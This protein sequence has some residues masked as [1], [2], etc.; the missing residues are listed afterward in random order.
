MTAPTWRTAQV[1]VLTLALIVFWIASVGSFHTHELLLG[2]PAV[3]LSTAFSFYAIR[4]LPIRFRPTLGNLLEIWRLPGYVVLDLLQILRVLALDL[5][6]RRAPSL[7][8][9]VPW[10]P[11]SPSPADVAL[12]SLAVACTTVSPNCVVIG[13]DRERRQFFFHQLA[14]DNLP[15]MTRRLGAGDP[16]NKPGAPS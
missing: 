10:F 8:R 11:V 12:R 6:G 14:P 2:V 13:I 1:F 15:A 3:L 9:S 4:Q 7:F 5:A 16:E